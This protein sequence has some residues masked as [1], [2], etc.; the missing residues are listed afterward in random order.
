MHI[1]LLWIGARFFTKPL[2]GVRVGLVWVGEG[3]WGGK[4]GE[5][6]EM[7]LEVLGST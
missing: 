6:G 7:A 2:V 5:G 4:E 1:N 3:W